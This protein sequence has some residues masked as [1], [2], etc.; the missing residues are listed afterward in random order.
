MQGKTAISIKGGGENGGECGGE[1]GGESQ[2]TL[3]PEM[4][5]MVQAMDQ[6]PEAIKA[7]IVAMI[8]ACT[9]PRA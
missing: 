6:M 2:L 7:G 9:V 5:R 8:E 4:L 3:S 1:C